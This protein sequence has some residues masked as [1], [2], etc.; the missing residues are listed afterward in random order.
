MNAEHN[1]LQTALTAARPTPDYDPS[2]YSP[3]ALRMRQAI[4]NQRPTTSQRFTKRQI[5]LT[6]TPAVA[7]AIAAVVAFIVVSPGSSGTVPSRPGDLRTAILDA[8]QHYAGDISYW[9]QYSQVPGHPATILRRA[10]SYP[11]FPAVGQTVSFR[12]LNYTSAGK[13]RDDTESFYRE[14]AG[15]QRFSMP[16]TDAPKSARIVGVDYLTHTWSRC[17]STGYPLNTG[18]SPAWLHAQIEHGVLTPV[19]VNLDGRQALRFRWNTG[20]PGDTE[21][22][23]V[24]ARTYALL[25]MTAVF[26]QTQTGRVGFT[27]T[28]VYSLIPATS[29]ALR[30]LT[31]PIPAGFTRGSQL[32]H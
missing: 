16:E 23:Y 18:A 12:V 4:L 32:C 20:I 8:W 14:N 19:R 28:V 24:D 17:I 11:A 15:M 25:R 5:V 26:T 31:P 6:A 10:W 7:V 3:A 29:S 2:P 21:Y 27:I 13:P 30:T 9:T 22:V 1:I